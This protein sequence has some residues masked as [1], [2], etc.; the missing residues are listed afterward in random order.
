M[1]LGEFHAWMDVPRSA[2][3]DWPT[4]C[5][6]SAHETLEDAA[7]A[8]HRPGRVGRSARDGPG[9]G[10]PVDGPC[11][12]CRPLRHPPK[13]L[14]VRPSNF[15]DHY[16]GEQLRAAGLSDAVPARRYQPGGAKGQADD[17]PGRETDSEGPRI[18]RGEIAVVLGRGGRQ[19][20]QGAGPRLRGGLRAVHND[21]SVREYQ[22]QD[23]AMDRRQRTSTPPAPSGPEP[24]HVGRNCRP[25]SRG[26]AAGNA[27]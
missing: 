14:C 24:D 6:C 26:L 23:A 22:F 8:R 12:G 17:P 25:G 2:V 16:Q 18:S 4:R 9:A 3:R 19:Y 13:I 1:R 5:A 7:G 21:G 10:W 20:R 27:P 15:A 11:T